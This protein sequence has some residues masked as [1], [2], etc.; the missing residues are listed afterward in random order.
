[1]K[2]NE[3]TN[4]LL[5]KISNLSVFL[6][7]YSSKEIFIAEYEDNSTSYLLKNIDLDKNTCIIEVR[8]GQG[9]ENVS[10]MFDKSKVFS[11]Y[12]SD[13]ISFI[14]IDGKG[15]LKEDNCD[16]VFYNEKNFCFVELKLN[17]TSLQEQTITGNR[18][19]AIK[20]LN[21]TINYFNEKLNQNYC[22]L[23]LEAFIATP[24][25]YP[26]EN[27]VS[28]SLRERFLIKTS[29]PLFENREKKY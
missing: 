27:A 11:I 28:R 17:A 26:R 7:K 15:L 1:M 24:D 9:K 14:P 2:R 12:N 23:E 20:Q 5:S 22:G 8:K 21:N 4:I 6:E 19:K 3:L 29:I 13:E 18:E 10:M 16:F 25:I